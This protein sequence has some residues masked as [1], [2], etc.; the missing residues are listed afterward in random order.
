MS[1]RSKAK[2]TSKGQITLPV[3]VRR[4]LGVA[5]G[6]DV[7]FEIASGQ[8]TVVPSPSENRFRKF[9]G[10]YRIGKGRTSAETDAFVRRLRGRTE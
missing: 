5:R 1:V 3:E 4:T 9:V 2:L 8:V 7:I 10:R 6:D